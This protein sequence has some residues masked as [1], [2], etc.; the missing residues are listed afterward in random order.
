MTKSFRAHAAALWGQCLHTN[1]KH[2]VLRVDLFGAGYF[3]KCR[4]VCL[5]MALSDEIVNKQHFLRIFCHEKK[6]TDF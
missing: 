1:V 2:V 6:Q 4:I 3:E 5:F